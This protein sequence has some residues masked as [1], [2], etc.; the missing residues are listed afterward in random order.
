MIPGLEDRVME[1]TDEDV[2][3]IA[4]LVRIFCFNAEAVPSSLNSMYRSRRALQVRDRMIL[5]A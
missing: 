5:R 4:E 2:A 1:G 3:R